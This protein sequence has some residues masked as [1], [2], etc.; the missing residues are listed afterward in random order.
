MANIYMS[1][2]VA[3]QCKFLFDL[4]TPVFELED[5][6]RNDL[7]VCTVQRQNYE[8]CDVLGLFRCTKGIAASKK[9]MSVELFLFNRSMRANKLIVS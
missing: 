8:I 6:S 3:F 7:L 5:V 4:S 2:N 9:N 1:M